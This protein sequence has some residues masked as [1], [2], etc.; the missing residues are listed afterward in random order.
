MLAGMCVLFVLDWHDLAFRDAARRVLDAASYAYMLLENE[1]RDV[2]KDI[3][4]DMFAFDF[5][6][7]CFKL[8]CKLVYKQGRQRWDWMTGSRL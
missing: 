1:V 3:G 8:A 7:Q 4:F 2:A 5:S 6:K